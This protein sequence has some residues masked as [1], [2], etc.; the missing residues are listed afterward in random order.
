MGALFLHGSRGGGNPLNF[1][2][3]GETTA[4]S[5]PRENDIWVNTDTPITSWIFSATE[6]SPAEAGMVWITVGTA[7][8]AEFNALKK[9]S[10]Q[11]YP[12]SAKQYIG[13][14]WVE[15]T[16]KSY[17]GGGW[18][19]WRRYLYNCGDECTDV[20]GGWSGYAYKSS[21]S[22]STVNAPTVT[23]GTG[24]ITVKQ[25]GYNSSSAK[26]YA[27]ALFSEKAVDLSNYGTMKINVTEFSGSSANLVVTKTKGNNYTIAGKVEIKSTG[28]FSVDVSSLSG[29]YYVALMIQGVQNAT[30]VTF[31]E[32]FLS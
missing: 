16:A 31:T 9:N 15:K 7:S 29:D 22:G 4:P 30:T 10:I 21:D 23:K 25:N 24:S 28:A 6:P 5:G 26:Y 8:T 18:V 27:G 14:A 12:M 1:R 19:D 32:I 17:L 11:V 2:V 13:G 3:L 20:S